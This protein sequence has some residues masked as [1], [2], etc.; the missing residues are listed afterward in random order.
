MVKNKVI[1]LGGSLIVP[2]SIDVP[3]LKKFKKIIDKKRSKFYIVC[4]GGITARNYIKAASNFTKD[5][6]HVGIKATWINAELVKSMFSDVHKHVLIKPKKTKEKIT[7]HGGN[8]PNRSSDYEAVE[9]GIFLKDAEVIN[10]TN[11]DYVYDKNPKKDKNTKPFEKLSWDEYKKICGNKWIPGLSLPFD[12]IAS[13]YAQKKGLRV[14]ILNGKNL[15]NFDNYLSGK[16]F[17]GTIIH[18]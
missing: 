8:K 16:K 13:K 1:S 11:V 4:G 18:P 3:F 7:I 12:P 17:K 6:D 15:K 14:V 2:N 9:V 5:T 10:L